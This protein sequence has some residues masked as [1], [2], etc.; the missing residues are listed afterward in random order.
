MKKTLIILVSIVL[1]SCSKETGKNET[2]KTAIDGYVNIYIKNSSGVDLLDSATYPKENYKVYYELNGQK[3]LY[4]NP[5]MDYP[6]GFFISNENNI[7]FLRLFLNIENNS[8]VTNT[9]I[10]WSPTQTDKL[11]T[12]FN[13]GENFIIA[14]KIFLNGNLV[15]TTL[16]I[17]GREITIIK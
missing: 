1:S 14:D 11:T 12:V 7:H 13:I 5:L 10:E 16:G 2:S 9:Y 17:T 3:I 8:V 15:N 4:K 6:G